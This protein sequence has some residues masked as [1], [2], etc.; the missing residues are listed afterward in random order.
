MSNE[1]TMR[2]TLLLNARLA[3]LV[4]GCALLLAANASAQVTSPVTFTMDNPFI[5]DNTTLPAG[6]YQILPTDDLGFL[7]LRNDKGA[8]ALFFEVVE[9][10]SDTPFKQ[11]EVL[12]NKYGNNLVLK[13]IRV[14]GQLI[15]DT[16]VISHAESSYSKNS[17]KPTKVTRPAK[18]TS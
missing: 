10:D 1:S 4:V 14:Q 8:R 13:S 16:T 2:P 3:V 7:E 5:V 17:G 15:G 6:S 12:F 18:T 11:T 9:V